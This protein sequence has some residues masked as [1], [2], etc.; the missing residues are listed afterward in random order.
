MLVT[1]ADVAG[2]PRA[3]STGYENTDPT[4]VTAPEKPATRPAP[5]RAGHV[6]TSRNPAIARTATHVS[7]LCAPER[8]QWREDGAVQVDLAADQ[9]TPRPPIGAPG[10]PP[11]LH[12]PDGLDSRH[13]RAQKSPAFR[14]LACQVAV[15]R[16]T[17]AF[18]G[19]AIHRFVNHLGL[20]EG[21]VGVYHPDLDIQ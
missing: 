19:A 7:I 11:L 15:G 4:P 12:D 14:R 18:D 1:L 2:K 3:S 6:I 17:V 16:C 20:E 9:P 10:E 5:I 8:S 13:V 21:S